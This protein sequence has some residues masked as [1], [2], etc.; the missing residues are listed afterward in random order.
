LAGVFDPSKSLQKLLADAVGRA[1]RR[2]DNHGLA[3]SLYWLG[4][5]SYSLGE[6]KAA[7]QHLGQ[8]LAVA[9]GLDDLLLVLQIKA[10]LGQ[11]LAAAGEYARAEPLLDEVIGTKRD[12]QGSGRVPLGIAF[13]L[14]IK[15]SILADRGCFDDAHTYFDK[16]LEIVVGSNHEVEASILTWRSAVYLWQGRWRDAL[17]QALAAQVIANRVKSLY[18]Y[19]MGVT[20]AAC[21]NW[22][23]DGSTAALD[24]LRE[25]TGWLE[26][27]DK[28]LCI[29]L[30]YGWL[31]H[32]M[33]A[34][35]QW[36][37]ARDFAAR[38]L[39]RG[40]QHEKFGEAMTY[41]ALAWA[42]AKLH[43]HNRPASVYLDLAFRSARARDSVHE[44]AVTQLCAA[45]IAREFGERQKAKQFV[46]QALAGFAK[47]DMVWHL[48]QAEKFA[49]RLGS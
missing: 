18:L 29:S 38:A 37:A 9:E 32:I 41:R 47:L 42:S 14:T 28:V 11:A 23:L 24:S 6:V 46:E 1:G 34:T 5:L 8:A 44:I 2:Q 30:N 27:Q 12:R 25:A 43:D 16:S 40:R 39:A 17:S 13:T 33:A 36:Q 48:A 35:G 22:R 3:R 45:E 21:A 19:S 26:A 10:T 49:S 20:L 4:Y 31:A 7:T 15:A